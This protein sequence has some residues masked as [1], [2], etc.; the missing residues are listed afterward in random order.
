MRK[1]SVIFSVT[2]I[3]YLLNAQ[4]SNKGESARVLIFKDQERIK[5]YSASNNSKIVNYLLNDTIKEDYYVI[6]VL[7]SKDNRYQI[8][9]TSLLHSGIK[10]WIELGNLGIN[11]RSRDSKLLL[12]EQPNYQSKSVTINLDYDRMVR[13]T[14]ISSNWLKILLIYENKTFNYWLPSEY[15]CPNPYTTC[16]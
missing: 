11:T 2:F 1:L 8:S 5:V 15:Q 13:V 9:A 3:F 16:N 12:Y 14:A 6:E 7:G 10:G 4:P